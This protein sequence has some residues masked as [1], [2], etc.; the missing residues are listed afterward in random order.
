MRPIIHSRKHYVQTSLT[1]VLAGAI[2]TQELAQAVIPPDLD[3]A[4]EVAEGANVK[5]VYIELWART[6]DTSAGSYV[7]IVE[8]LP[9][10]GG[11]ITAA[12]MAA[13]NN[14]ENKKNIFFSSQ[15]LLNVKT[16]DSIPIHRGWIKVPKSKQRMGLDDR[17]RWTF[18][19]QAL[20]SVICGI[21]TYKEYT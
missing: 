4:T 21:S 5:A 7:F 3:T 9:G 1:S 14:Y 2:N 20:E 15:A 17:I 11:A 19:S 13:L 18:F 12:N 16:A 6:N 8:K 10:V